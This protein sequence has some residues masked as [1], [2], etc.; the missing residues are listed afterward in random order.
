L[1]F[2]RFLSF[3]VD[4]TMH[5]TVGNIQTT[6]RFTIFA[7]SAAMLQVSLQSSDH[8]EIMNDPNSQE[9]TSRS[10][11]RNSQTFLQLT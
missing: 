1:I 5:Q 11:T 9:T 2:P 6:P 3:P 7:S 10:T 4:L 8:K